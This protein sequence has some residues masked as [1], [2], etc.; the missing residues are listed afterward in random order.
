MHQG[1][2][3]F[4]F[5]VSAFLVLLFLGLGFTDDQPVRTI[6]LKIAADEEFRA[7]NTWSMQVRR[8]VKDVS[9][10]FERKY[11]LRFEIKK[12]E[13]WIS[14]NHTDSMY[15][16][17]NDLRK[18]VY[19]GD[20]DIVVGITGQPIHRTD[21]SGLATYLR[22]Y[23]LLRR[24]G[25]DLAM[26]VTLAHEFCHLFGAVDMNEEG[27]IMDT[28]KLGDVFDP[29]T[30][31]IIRINKFR[32]FI[33]HIF[34]LAKDNWDAAV[35]AYQKRKSLGKNETDLNIALATLFLEKEN[36]DAVIAECLEVLQIKS[37]LPEVYNLLG[38]AYRRKGEVDKALEQYRTFLRMQPNLPEIHYN[39]GIA[40]SKKGQIPESIK[41]YKR[42]IEL[43]PY[44]A[45]AYANLAY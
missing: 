24:M 4:L 23:I 22:S 12:Q 30:S 31:E 34:P 14:H 17:L 19:P 15:D 25:S 38:I 39:M 35:S 27:S 2:K 11:G 16:L 33:P 26:K 18:K 32:N 20:C 9:G 36:Y 6:T 43:N 1:R 10:R 5:L 40:L 44:Y 13:F 3:G 8:I 41:E 21:F 29:F 28:K 7:Q 45:K 37:D 42:A